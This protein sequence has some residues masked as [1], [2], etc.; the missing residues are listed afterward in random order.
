MRGK[1]KKRRLRLVE[2]SKGGR[3]FEDLQLE[4]RVLVF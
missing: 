4:R 3:G 1:K 2:D